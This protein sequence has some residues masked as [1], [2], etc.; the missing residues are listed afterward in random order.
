MRD[1]IWNVS[2][3]LTLLRVLLVVPIACLLVLGDPSSRM[4]A[5]GLIAVA[6]LSDFLD[7]MIARKL[8][9]VTEFG[10]I[11]DPL[12]DKVAVGVVACIL[13]WQGKLP[14]WFLILVLLR[15][16]AILSGGI[17]LRRTRGIVLQSN[18]TGKW[19]VTFIAAL[20]LLCVL[21]PAGAAWPHDLLLA[22]STLLLVISSALYLGRFLAVRRGGEA[23][24]S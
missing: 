10:K 9:Q 4:L 11:L 1:S 17:Y 23:G 5:V 21:D 8:R 19:A 15:D 18:K 3:S 2:N 7:G 13:A 6:T 20:I 22:S 14:F 24:T 16:G 12:A